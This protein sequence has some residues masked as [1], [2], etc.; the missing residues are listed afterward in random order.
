MNDQQKTRGLTA[1]AFGL[2]I[3]AAV[4]VVIVILTFA[5]FEGEEG[6]FYVA[7]MAVAAAGAFVAW[8]F[9]ATWARI[10]GLIITLA[11]LA[12]SFWFA[13][14]V[15]QPF[16]PL[17]FITGLGYLIGILFA[18][19]GGFAGLF[20]RGGA[21]R[22]RLQSGA[23]AL[24][25]VLSVVSIAGFVFTRSSVSEA[26]AAGA[27]VLDMVDF[28]F[29]PGLTT[30]ATGDKLLLTNSDPFAH[31][32]TLD[33]PELYVYLGPGGETLV[34]LSSVPAGTYEYWCSLHTFEEDGVKDGMVGTITIES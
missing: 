12:M 26:D 24:I 27:T 9:D 5:L 10:L 19:I 23:L 33:D 28:E 1:Q 4:M 3:V 11:V 32:L 21:T 22:K 7:I 15:F 2:A 20:R 6:G 17:E 25:G 16:S 31:D 30:V 29:A 18:L 34:D 8:R 13:F 14:G